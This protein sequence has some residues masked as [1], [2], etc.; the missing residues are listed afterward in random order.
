MLV[1][2]KVILINEKKTPP[3]FSGGV[4]VRRLKEKL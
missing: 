2:V 3:D 1:I 4:D